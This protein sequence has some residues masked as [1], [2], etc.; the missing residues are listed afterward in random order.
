MD[1]CHFSMFVSRFKVSFHSAVSCFKVWVISVVGFTFTDVYA[2]EYA[3][4]AREE[5]K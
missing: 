1:I 4:V 5:R 2:Y 3:Y